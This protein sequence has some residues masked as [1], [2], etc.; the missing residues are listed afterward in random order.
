MSGAL[1]NN[2]IHAAYLT[3]DHNSVV[4]AYTTG[5]VLCAIL[6]LWKPSRYTLL[7]LLG[8][9][10]LAVGFEY[11]KHLVGPLVRQTLESVVGEPENGARTAKLINVFLGEVIPIAL[12]VFGWFF[13]FIATIIGAG[14]YEKRL[15]KRQ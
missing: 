2:L 7:T 11:D 9:L 13:I 1:I 6:S 4:L 10:T 14:R 8:F 3:F 15:T 12:F 5:F